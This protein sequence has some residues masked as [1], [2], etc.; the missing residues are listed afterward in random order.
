MRLLDLNEER[1]IKKIGLKLKEQNKKI[2]SISSNLL[3][4]NRNN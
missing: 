2:N 1:N 4:A 3:N